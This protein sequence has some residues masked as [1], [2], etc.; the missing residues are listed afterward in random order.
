M[1]GGSTGRIKLLSVQRQK[2]YK[3][4]SVHG[5]KQ[6][7]AVVLWYYTVIRVQASQNPFMINEVI[8]RRPDIKPKPLHYQKEL[9]NCM[10]LNRNVGKEQTFPENALT[11]WVWMAATVLV[12]QFV[13]YNYPRH[14]R[15]HMSHGKQCANSCR[16]RRNGRHV[17]VYN[18][19]YI[20]FNEK[21]GF[22]LKYHW[23][24]PPWVQL[25]RIQHWFKQWLDAK[26]RQS[27][28]WTNYGLVYWH[29]YAS[30]C[31]HELVSL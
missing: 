17:A 26:R 29:I 10:A 23:I 20:L 4:F 5:F 25:T 11:I 1:I 7:H 3:T 12:P 27:I 15:H 22:R 28:I 21:F 14:R 13:P 31:F 24:L 8:Y 9:C 18:F 19:K 16:P 6:T 30:E 2:L